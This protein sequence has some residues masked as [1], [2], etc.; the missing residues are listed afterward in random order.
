MRSSTPPAS[1][2]SRRS[3]RG[4]ST[5][6]TPIPRTGHR[7]HTSEQLLML[8]ARRGAVPILDYLFRQVY[9]ASV[10]WSVDSPP[11]GLPELYLLDIAAES[12]REEAV[13]Y[14]LGKGFPVSSSILEEAV[15]YGNPT[16]VQLCLDRA[17]VEPNFAL[18]VAVQK[19]DNRVLRM[20]LDGDVGRAD[21]WYKKILQEIAREQGLESM[22]KL[23]LE[24]WED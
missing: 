18:E 20:L 24:H 9:P 12:G 5:T 16:I 13:V 22:E 19:E 11:D 7:R 1:T 2:S 23:L 21:Y 10:S 4:P 14:L 8:A 3:T 17:P 15:Q 6:S